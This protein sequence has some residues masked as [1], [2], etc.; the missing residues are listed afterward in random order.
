M[1]ETFNYPAE[2]PRDLIRVCQ[3]I[4]VVYGTGPLYESLRKIFNGGFQPTALHKFSG[5]LPEKI[6]K[7]PNPLQQKQLLIV[8]TNYDDLMEQALTDRGIAFDVVAYLADGKE[9]GK[10]VHHPPTGAPVLID[11]PNEYTAL[12]F[13]RP[14]ILKM[15]G[16][17]DRNDNSNDSF[18]ITE[19]HYI[20]YLTRTDI[21]NFIP[22]TLAARLKTSH[23]LFLGYSLRDWNVRVILD[24]IWGAQKLSYKSWSVQKDS[25]PIDRKFWDRRGVEI[26]D[27]DLANYVKRMSAATTAQ[28]ATGD[29]Q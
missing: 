4:A 22:V 5:S 15:H 10:F 18:V 26:I 2:D 12:T 11:R 29:R 3:Y 9:S 27:F 28:G 19:D 20:E 13:D 17:I 16:A 21:S 1:A 7:Q 23:F 8:T 6:T 14:V 24:R 25:S